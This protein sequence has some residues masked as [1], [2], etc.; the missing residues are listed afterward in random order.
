M[1]LKTTVAYIDTDIENIT[2][3][4]LFWLSDC[5]VQKHKCKNSLKF[6]IPSHIMVM[7]GISMLFFQ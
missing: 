3:D 1:K 4:Q 2:Y 6:K 7:F 5:F